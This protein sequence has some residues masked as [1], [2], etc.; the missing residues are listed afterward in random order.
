[1]A[2]NQLKQLVSSKTVFF[3]HNAPIHWFI[4]SLKMNGYYR[5]GNVSPLLS[6]GNNWKSVF[7]AF[8]DAH[9]SE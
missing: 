7:V 1:M 4:G 3:S 9:N 5:E 2:A 6:A 8:L